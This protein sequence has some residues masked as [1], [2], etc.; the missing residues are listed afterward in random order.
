MIIRERRGRN[1]GFNSNQILLDD[2]DLHSA[3][4]YRGLYVGGEV[5]SIG[6]S[7]QCMVSLSFHAGP[8]V[9]AVVGD[10]MPRYCLFGDTV[11]IASRMEST[12]QG[13]LTHYF[14]L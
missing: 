14:V 11:S 3:S 7:C 9:A 6:L 10:R 5:C 12:G 2:S 1:Y 8:C 4:T 13:L